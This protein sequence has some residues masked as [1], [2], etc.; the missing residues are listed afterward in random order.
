MHGHALAQ[1]EPFLHD[2]AKVLDVGS[3]SGY[4]TTCFAH[5]V[6][7]SGVVY[8]IDHITEL[9]DMA[10]RNIRK[11]KPEFLEKGIIKLVVGDGIVKKFPRS[12]LNL[13]H[14]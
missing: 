4:L 2:G 1:L 9:V 3:G 7:P 6:Q 10:R 14:R 5:F 13:G 12:F 8:G 11:D